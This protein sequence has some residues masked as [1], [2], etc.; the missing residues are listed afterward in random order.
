MTYCIV[1]DLG[2]SDNNSFSEIDMYEI[3]FIVNVLI[4]LFVLL[5]VGIQDLL[6][7]QVSVIVCNDVRDAVFGL[8]THFLPS[9][10]FSKITSPLPSF[11]Q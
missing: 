2:I 11:F 8:Y 3:D 1:L 4:L 10:P 6:G 9:L 7:I 5:S